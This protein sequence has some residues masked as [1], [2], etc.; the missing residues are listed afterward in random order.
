MGSGPS[1][2]GRWADFIA[3]EGLA[4]AKDAAG[5]ILRMFPAGERHQYAP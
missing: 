5:T 3:E 4:L 2:W 1:T